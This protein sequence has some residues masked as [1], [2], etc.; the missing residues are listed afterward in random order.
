MARKPAKPDD[1]EIAAV[2][3]QLDAL[4]DDLAGSVDA[5]SALLRRPAQ[6]SGSDDE[7]LAP[8]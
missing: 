8:L 1:A 6:P 4:L 3:R 2:A 5:L 7:R